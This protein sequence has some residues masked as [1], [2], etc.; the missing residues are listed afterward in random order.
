MNRFANDIQAS[1]M[2]HKRKIRTVL[3]VI[4]VSLSVFAYSATIIGSCNNGEWY[5]QFSSYDACMS[6]KDRH[7]A[8]TGHGGTCR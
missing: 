7:K 1:V 3:L 8:Q 4:S 2:D 5:K 6:A